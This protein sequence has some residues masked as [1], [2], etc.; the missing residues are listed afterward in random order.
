L[1]LRLLNFSRSPLVL[2]KAKIMFHNTSHQLFF[3]P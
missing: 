1:P 3:N 2:N